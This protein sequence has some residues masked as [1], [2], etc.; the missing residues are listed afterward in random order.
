MAASQD[1]FREAIIGADPALSRYDPL[2]R[3]VFYD[4][5]DQGLSGWT[6]LRGNY[7][8]A[9][10]TLFHLLPWN[11]DYR[12]PM[13]SN[14]T[15][16]DTGTH[17]AM[18]GAYALKIASRPQAGHFA[19]ALKRITWARRGVYQ[20]ECYFTYK[21][22]PSSL[23][24]GEDVLGSFGVNL[25]LHDNDNRYRLAIRYLNARD[26]EMCQKW[27]YLARGPI[28]PRENGWGPEAYRDIPAGGQK[29]CYNE[30]VTKSN[31]HYLRWVVD[32]RKR[33]Y[34]EFQCNDHQFDM[35]GMGPEVSPPFDNLWCLLNLG[36]SVHAD[37]DVRCFFL[38]DSVLLSMEL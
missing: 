11:R 33:E 32:L 15:M 25:D 28:I 26:G 9:D 34:V 38:V 31:W 37:A 36:F 35:R 29:L 2:A 12:P 23:G 24:L 27:Q 17:G 5:F 8:G 22:E 7:S 1:S 30:T 14:M 20:A 18:Q 13:L 4:D 10:A 3:I 16:P 19:D 6:E 21:S